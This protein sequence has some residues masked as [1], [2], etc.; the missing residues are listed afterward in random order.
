MLYFVVD[1]NG[2]IIAGL[3]YTLQ[4]AEYTAMMN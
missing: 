4:N 1:E 3:R 2:K